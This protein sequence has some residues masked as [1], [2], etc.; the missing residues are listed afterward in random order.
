MVAIQ[1]VGDATLEFDRSGPADE[2]DVTYF[3]YSV[4]GVTYNKILRRQ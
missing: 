4:D 3:T 2:P 1:S